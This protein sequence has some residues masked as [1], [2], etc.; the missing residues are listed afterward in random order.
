MI[1][2]KIILS[3]FTITIALH[4]SFAEELQQQDSQATTCGTHTSSVEEA[5]QDCSKLP[6]AIDQY[7]MVLVIRYTHTTKSEV[8]IPSDYRIDPSTGLIW[9]QRVNI[10][11]DDFGIYRSFVTHYSHQS[12]FSFKANKVNN[13][14]WDRFLYTFDG[15]HYHPDNYL[16]Y[17]APLGCFTIA[18][19]VQPSNSNEMLDLSI[20]TVAELKSYFARGISLEKNTPYW[21]ADVSSARHHHVVFGSGTVSELHDKKGRAAAICV[22]RPQNGQLPMQELDL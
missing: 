2:S 14:L 4:P 20:P 12:L 16:N 3:L 18:H 10:G 8:K 19:L 15:T 9:S 11:Y 1:M 21:S 22:G 17:G 7:G 6:D 5:I 13:S